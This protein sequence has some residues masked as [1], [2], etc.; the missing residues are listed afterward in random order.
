MQVV[1]VTFL[2]HDNGQSITVGICHDATHSWLVDA[3]TTEPIEEPL[4]SKLINMLKV[5]AFVI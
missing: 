1:E 2:N 3:E 4:N 5:A